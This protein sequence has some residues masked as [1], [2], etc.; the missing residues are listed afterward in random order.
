MCPSDIDKCLRMYNND[1]STFRTHSV[2][3][4]YI[5]SK[6]IHFAAAMNLP[7][8]IHTERTHPSPSQGQLIV[9]EL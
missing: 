8:S 3:T 4:N 5:L 1:T 9:T 7:A 2:K 6:P